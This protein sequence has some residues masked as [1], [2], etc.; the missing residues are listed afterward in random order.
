[1]E[2]YERLEHV[3]RFSLDLL[4]AIPAH[5]PM[6]YTTIASEQSAGD[7]TSILL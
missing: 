1:M 5:G 6:S 3:A 2:T 7:L 4:A